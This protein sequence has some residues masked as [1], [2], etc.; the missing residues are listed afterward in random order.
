MSNRTRGDYHERRTRAQLE[1]LGWFVIRAGGSL[2]PAD[3]VALR[4]DRRPWLVACKI[5]GS[6]SFGELTG[7]WIAAIQAGAHPI[8]ARRNGRGRIGWALLLEPP[9]RNQRHVLE[10]IE[11]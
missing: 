5:N 4:S 10:D 3:L 1:S 11:P 7:L 9:V 2:G 8:V 6:A